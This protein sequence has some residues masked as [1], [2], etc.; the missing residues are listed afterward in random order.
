MRNLRTELLARQEHHVES[1]REEGG[2]LT[3]GSVAGACRVVVVSDT[4]LSVRAPE[5]EHNWS[6]VLRHVEKTRP[7][8]VVHA[9]DLSL[10]GADVAEDLSHSR[11][12]LDLLPTRWRAV[13]GN[14]DIGDNPRPDADTVSDETVDAGRLGRWRDVVGDDSWC[15]VESGWRL[16]GVNAQLFGSGLLD[17]ERQ[18]DRLDAELT[19]PRVPTVLFTH[20]P[21]TAGDDELASTPS[22][23]FVPPP[24]R[25][26]LVEL[27][28]QGG[29]ALVVSGH[30]HQSRALG[31]AGLAHLWAPTTWAVLP[32]WLQPPIGTKRCGI[33]ELDLRDDG[34]FDS[35]WVEPAGMRQLTLEEDIASP[36]RSEDDPPS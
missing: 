1:S 32:D 23:R 18:W 11:S 21:L 6:A 17:E 29:V 34:G 12:Q 22:Y 15:T 36:Y 4:H 9:G 27:C 10:Q 13:P 25:G 35:R 7:D 28:Q 33:L 2:P 5:A 19:G 16:V 20:K 30:V 24:A 31:T 14:H 3:S 8:L 26:R